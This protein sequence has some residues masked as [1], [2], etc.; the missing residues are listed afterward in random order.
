[1]GWE[2]V[3]GFGEDLTVGCYK[4]QTGKYLRAFRKTHY[5]H[6]QGQAIYRT[7]HVVNDSPVETASHP[8][9]P[10]NPN[11]IQLRGDTT[12]MATLVHLNLFYCLCT[13]LYYVQQPSCEN[14]RINRNV[15]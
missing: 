4:M 10:W 3:S 5:L 8:G 13:I 12:K 6:L 15:D 9:K 7:L 14:T 11:S 2:S 1:M